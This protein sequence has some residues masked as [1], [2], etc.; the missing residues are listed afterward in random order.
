MKNASRFIVALPLMTQ[1]LFFVARYFI[2][3][4]IM[5]LTFEK[6]I[7][8]S[9]D[10]CF[11][12]ISLYKYFLFHYQAKVAINRNLATS[13][14]NIIKRQRTSRAILNVI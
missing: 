13:K 4:S 10:V 14:K 5:V 3:F 6:E 1:Q 12:T 9:R 7:V 11:L 8:N 2:K